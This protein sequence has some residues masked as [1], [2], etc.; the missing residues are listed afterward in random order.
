MER[1]SSIRL[2]PLEKLW[3]NSWL[4][5]TC[6]EK[7][8]KE[9]LSAKIEK[10]KVDLAIIGQMEAEDKETL[11]A[12]YLDCLDVSTAKHRYDEQV[13]RK[14]KLEEARKAAELRRQEAKPVNVPIYQKP[15]EMPV[16]G[17]E[18]VEELYTRAFRVV[19]CTRQQIIDLGNWMNAHGIRFE[20]IEEEK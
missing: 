14:R 18:K 11:K 4:N 5:K 8:W 13:E 7:S 1:S 6:S 2:I 17:G 10:I 19:G 16:S 3:E 9:Q 15:A 12:M 20:K